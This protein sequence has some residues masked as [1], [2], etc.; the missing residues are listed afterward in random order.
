MTHSL[1]FIAAFTL[2]SLAA[3]AS[4]AVNTDD[5]GLAL[6]GHDPVAFFTLGAAVQGKSSITAEHEGATYQFAKTAHR[7]LFLA[8]PE[9]YLPAYGG[10]CGFGAAKGKLFPVEID[11]WQITGGRLIL[12]YNAEIKA[13]FDADIDALIE[14][15]D[16]NWPSL[17][18]S[19]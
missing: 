14:R 12:N 18:A 16:A 1:R 2:L 5:N 10:Y 6:S 9:R 8:S 15:A 7:D 17:N 19:E 13:Q 3:Q 11:T 4:A